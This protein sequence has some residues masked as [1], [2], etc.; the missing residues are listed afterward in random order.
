MTCQSGRASCS[1][2]LCLC[3]TPSK[4]GSALKNR[5]NSLVL[6]LSACSLVSVE[7]ILCGELR[8]AE[9]LCGCLI[10]AVDGVDALLEGVRR[11][12]LE[13]PV[14]EDAACTGDMHMRSFPSG[15]RQRKQLGGEA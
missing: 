4:V 12:R 3:G 15:S 8:V 9:D 1:A 14:Q 7:G 13:G 11:R 5:S 10:G 6:H 2:T